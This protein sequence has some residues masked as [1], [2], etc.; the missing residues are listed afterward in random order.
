[1]LR[2]TS[3]IPYSRVPVLFRTQEYQYYS[4]LRSTNLKLKLQCTPTAYASYLTGCPSIP[5]DVAHVE[6]RGKAMGKTGVQKA[7]LRHLV[8]ELP[9]GH[10]CS[11][12]VDDAKVGH[13]DFLSRGVA[14][15]G[16]RVEHKALACGEPLLRLVLL[17]CILLLDV[18]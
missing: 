16:R 9:V 13:G 3:T 15:N 2:S 4:V 14:V 7:K 5:H 18:I 8:L 6:T 17:L 12:P 10:S 11:V 1:M